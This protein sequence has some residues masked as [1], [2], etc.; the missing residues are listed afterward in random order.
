MLQRGSQLREIG[1]TIDG[2]PVS[3]A[4]RRSVRPRDGQRYSA[5]WAPF[6]DEH[7]LGSG[8]TLL[9]DDNQALAKERVKRVGDDD[10]FRKWVRLGGTGAMRAPSGCRVAGSGP[11]FPAWGCAPA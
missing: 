5:G 11:A 8:T 6:A 7:S 2:K 9:K 4:S 3:Q 10:R 1:Q